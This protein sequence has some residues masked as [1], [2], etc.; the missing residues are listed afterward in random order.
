MS[1]LAIAAHNAPLILRGI[2]EYNIAS[3]FRALQPR[4]WLFPV[5]YRC[6][7][8]CV[9][10]SIWQTDKSGELSLEDWRGTLG[11]R[12]FA[13]VESVSLTGGEPT[14]R[15][16]LPRLTELLIQKLPA[17]R[18]LTITTNALATE[19]VVQQCETVL[20]LSAAH[21]VG[22]FVGISLDGLGAVHDEMRGIPGAFDSVER[23]LRGLR[24]LQPRGL[25]MG[26]NC[27]LTS[28]NLRE[29]SKL[30]QWSLER[31]LPINWIVASFADS[32]YG[33]SA[34]E[35]QLALTPEENNLLVGLL[36]DLARRKTLGNLAAYFYA[37]AAGM[38]E[39]G[40]RRTTPCVFQKDGFMLDA[41]GDLQYCMY[42]PVLGNVKRQ[43]GAEAY[44]AAENLGHRRELLANRCRNCTITCFL[45]LALA[46]DA[47]RYTRFLLGGQP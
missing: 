45:E 44:F 9:M 16:D 43:S 35:D 30:R 7:A 40:K 25:R 24:G 17:L 39:R 26:I 32:Y 14:L 41:R 1:R 3:R 42:S 31:G 11:D 15:R 4:E 46:K 34:C 47:L 36:R 37:D 20:H 2:Y 5:T 21:G 12:L 29:A 19:R 6:D 38:I 27:T 10:C 13:G 8:R 22:L 28:R 18:R 23:T 33:N